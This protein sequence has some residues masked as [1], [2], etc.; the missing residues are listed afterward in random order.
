[1]LVLNV[2]FENEDNSLRIPFLFLLLH[3]TFDVWFGNN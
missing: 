1:M 2:L 3:Y